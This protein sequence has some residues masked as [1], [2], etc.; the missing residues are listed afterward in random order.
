MFDLSSGFAA[1]ATIGLVIALRHEVKLFLDERV[2]ESEQIPSGELSIINPICDGNLES[3]CALIHEFHIETMSDRL[4]FQRLL[5]L[6]LLYW[7]KCDYVRFIDES[8]TVL[9][10]MPTSMPSAELELFW[11]LRG[12]KENVVS[13]EDSLFQMRRSSVLLQRWMKNIYYKG[14]S[15]LCRHKVI[16]HEEANEGSSYQLTS[17]GEATLVHA[18]QHL[19][20]LQQ[21]FSWNEPGNAAVWNHYLTEAQLFGFGAELGERLDKIDPMYFMLEWGMSYTGWERLR[22][23]TESFST[24]AAEAVFPE[25]ELLQA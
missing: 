21:S 5:A 7:A 23:A 17:Y 22:T 6:Y 15:N 8:L 1:A 18:K 24:K 25:Q 10:E 20:Y 16:T 4:L 19:A 11:A 3:L 2:A 13:L 9:K 14:V 12:K